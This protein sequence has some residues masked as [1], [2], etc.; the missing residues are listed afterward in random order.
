MTMNIALENMDFWYFFFFL[1]Q[2]LLNRQ[3][4]HVSG[5]TRGYM[6][7]NFSQFGIL[8]LLTFPLWS[9]RVCLH[10]MF[11]QAGSVSGVQRRT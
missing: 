10:S 8:S 4:Y 5:I 3:T 9:V 11:R 6:A 7:N 1:N 2:N